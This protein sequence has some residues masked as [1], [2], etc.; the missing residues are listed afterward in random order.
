M[1]KTP[2]YMQ[3]YNYIKNAIQCDAYKVGEYLPPEPELEKMF[4]VS[5]TTVRK[6]V[7][8]LVREGFLLVQ[9]G[10]GTEIINNK[11]VHQQTVMSSFSKTL[12]KSGKTFEARDISVNN[13]VPDEL[14]RNKL[15]LAEGERVTRIYGVLCADGKPIAIR[16]TYVLSYL[17]P[18]I[19]K[20]IDSTT[21]I[22][23]CYKEHY[24][25]VFESAVDKFS[26]RPADAAEAEILGVPAGESMICL[27]RLSYLN[28]RPVERIE[29]DVLGRE[30][31]FEINIANPDFG[32]GNN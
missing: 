6:A 18:G 7:E 22:Y 20:F 21:S 9:Q 25:L 12:R 14:V 8:M 5:R 3:V 30:Y 13:I 4:G 11:T 28:G 26:A 1:N 19:E 15:R 31:E 2:A 24:N 23:D 10:R 16:K 17:T 27:R 29:L 32:G